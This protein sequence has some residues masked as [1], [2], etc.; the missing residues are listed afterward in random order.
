MPPADRGEARERVVQRRQKPSAFG[1]ERDVA[2]TRGA[3]AQGVRVRRLDARRVETQR[4][5][6]PAAELQPADGIAIGEVPD[7]DFVVD[8]EIEA[9]V[10]QIG[11]VGRRHDMVARRLHGS[12]GA[13]ETFT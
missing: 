12:T 2:R 11:D 5:G 9:R 6:D 1:G 4:F 8:D 7:A 10:D 3:P 13:P